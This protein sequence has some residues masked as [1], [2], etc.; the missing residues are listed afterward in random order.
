MAAGLLAAVVLAA[1]PFI[2]ATE[3]GF[4]GA[5]LLGFALGWA[6]LAVLS[7]RFSDQP[8]RWAAAPA[9]FMGVAG[10]IVLT[11]VPP[12]SSTMSWAGCGPRCCWFW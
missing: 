10:V 3:E 11:S 6:L 2:P 8:Q 12:R 1:A 7:I 5:V 4:T 9:L